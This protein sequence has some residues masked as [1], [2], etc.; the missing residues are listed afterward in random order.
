MRSNWAVLELEQLEKLILAIL[1]VVWFILKL[2]YEDFSVGPIRY[3]FIKLMIH[4][5]W[6]MFNRCISVLFR[7]DSLLIYKNKPV[8]R[9]HVLNLLLKVRNTFWVNSIFSLTKLCVLIM[10][11]QKKGLQTHIIIFTLIAH[12]MN[13]LL[14]IVPVNAKHTSLWISFQRLQRAFWLLL[15]WIKLFVIFFCALMVI[16]HA[17]ECIA[18]TFAISS[19]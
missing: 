16:K 5:C 6:V 9:P 7:I 14:F 17:F 10:T 12:N 4:D 3:F 15:N 19:E 2:L 13:R 1:E 18:I 11:G 8:R